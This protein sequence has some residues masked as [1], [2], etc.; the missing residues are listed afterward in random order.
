[1]MLLAVAAASP[2]SMSRSRAKKLA[3]IANTKMTR[4][5]YPAI[6]A[7]WRGDISA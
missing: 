4:Y 6:L 1:M 3:K 5:P 7:A 2:G